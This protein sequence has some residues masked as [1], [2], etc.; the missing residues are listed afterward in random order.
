MNSERKGCIEISTEVLEQLI[1]KSI[2]V[3]KDKE[4]VLFPKLGYPCSGVI[5]HGCQRKYTMDPWYI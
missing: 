2:T 1:Q 4:R 3:S 5:K